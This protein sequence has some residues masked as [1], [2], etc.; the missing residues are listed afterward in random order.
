MSAPDQANVRNRLL[1]A[2]APADYDRLKAKLNHV[3]TPKGTVVIKEDVP[4]PLCLFFESGLGS[5]L[6]H[7]PGGQT[8]EV[9]LYGFEGFAGLPILLESGHSPHRLEM[10]IGGTAYAIPSEVMRDALRESETLRAVM[11][12]YLQFFMLQVAQTTVSNALHPVDERLARWLLMG[13][14][15]MPDDEVPLTH[16]YLS[17]MLA[18]T[19]T[20]VTAALSTLADAGMVRTGR[21]SI[22]ILNRTGLE[23][24]AAHS[25]GLA[26]REYNRLISKTFS[27]GSA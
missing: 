15:R 19:R 21:G 13:H 5:V 12:R 10:Q 4:P 23:R 3:E 22:T 16:E 20:T 25:Y 27:V 14:D 7:V 6:A 11:L 9:G 26:E 17:F 1:R 2:L 24:V 8:A 18:A